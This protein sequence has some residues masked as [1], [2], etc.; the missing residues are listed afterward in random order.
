MSLY[1]YICTLVSWI[2]FKKGNESKIDITILSS[3]NVYANLL[4]GVD[5]DNWTFKHYV[6]T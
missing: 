4:Y 6:I 3:R 2:N 5:L 1:K